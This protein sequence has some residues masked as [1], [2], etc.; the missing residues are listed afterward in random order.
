M[1]PEHARTAAKRLGGQED[2]KFQAFIVQ[3]KSA[4]Q[5]PRGPMASNLSGCSTEYDIVCS[6]QKLLGTPC[7]A[8]LGATKGS[9]KKHGK[10]GCTRSVIFLGPGRGEGRGRPLL[11]PVVSLSKTLLLVL[12]Y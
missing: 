10:R 12:L 7:L 6:L 1:V 2:C 5:L 9:D 11:L 8:R 4:P 3:V